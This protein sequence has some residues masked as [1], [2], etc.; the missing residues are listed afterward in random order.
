MKK[1]FLRFTFP[2]YIKNCTA[3][4]TRYMHTANPNTYRSGDK[5]KGRTRK[6]SCSYIILRAEFK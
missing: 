4:P 6:N 5:R 2:F 3:N 1:S